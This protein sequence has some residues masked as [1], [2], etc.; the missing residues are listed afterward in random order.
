MKPRRLSEG[1]KKPVKL[2]IPLVYTVCNKSQWS[3]IFLKVSTIYTEMESLEQNEIVETPDTPAEEVPEEV[4]NVE[5]AEVAPEQE[6]EPVQD[7]EDEEEDDAEANSKCVQYALCEPASY[8]HRL[9]KIYFVLSIA[10]AISGVLLS[11]IL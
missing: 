10:G 4:E 1:K 7:E 2:A 8:I 3:I 9:T 11:S 6:E 5:E